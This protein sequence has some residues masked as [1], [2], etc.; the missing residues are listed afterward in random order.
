MF[1]RFVRLA[2]ARRALRAGHY[3]EALR[4]VDDPL[5][6][7]QRRSEELRR[8]ILAALTAR[9]RRRLEGGAISAARVDVERVLGEAGDDA[10]AQ[11]LKAELGARAAETDDRRASQLALLRDARRALGAADPNAAE[12]LVRTASALGPS[13]ELE[14][15]ISAIH[16]ARQRCAE[17]LES[18]AAAGAEGRC[19]DAAAAFAQA[20]AIDRGS[21][22]LASALRDFL[23][24]QGEALVREIER[25]GFEVAIELARW[26][27]SLPE[28]EGV[29]GLTALAK[30]HAASGRERV[31]AALCADDLVAVRA[32]RRDLPQDE[33][34]ERLLELCTVLERAHAAL[35]QG[36]PGAAAAAYA[37]LAEALATPR[38]LA[39]AAELRESVAFADAG[40][41]RARAHALEGRLSEAR[42]ELLGVIARCGAH[43]RAREELEVL[44][45][46]VADRER[47][48]AEAR[49]LLRE[50]RLREASGIVVALAVPGAEGEEPRLLLREIRQRTEIVDAG[51]RQVAVRMH[52]RSSGGREGL[53]QSARRVAELMKLQ[54]D[55][56]ELIRM[57]DAIAAELSGLAL[58]ERL[59]ADFEAGKVAELESGLDELLKLRTRLLTVDRL[60]ARA[61]ELVDDV[62]LGAERAAATGATGRAGALARALAG[63]DPHAP[64]LA[65]RRRA[66]ADSVQA[67][68]GR[69]RVV[70]EQARAALAVNDLARAE[71]LRDAAMALALDDVEVLRLAEELG[72]ARREDDRL[73][74]VARHADERD[75][76]AAHRE[77]GRL[78]PTP[79]LMRTRVFDLKRA[80]AK[81]QGLEGAFMLRVDEGGEFLVVRGESL[82]IG[83]LR[84]GSADLPMLANLAGRHARLRRSMSFHGGQQDRIVAEGGELSADGQRVA[85]LA[86]RGRTRFKLG[87][88]VELEY[89]LPNPRSLTALLTVQGGFQI[90]G[91]D[92]VLWMKDRGRD[93]RIL[94][95]PDRDAHV[96][97][98]GLSRELEIF[99][100]RDGRVRIAVQGPATMDGKPFTG[101]HPVTA[102][103]SI[104]VENIALVMLAWHR[105]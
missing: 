10:K 21:A 12:N 20:K 64:G 51:L 77:L 32:A 31:L 16:A 42:A 98:A 41:A 103:A 93:G 19:R 59:R 15:V 5:L 76:G 1:D 8:E 100:D 85:E 56:P 63:W 95:G 61:L 14:R 44:D 78:G 13:Q 72:R 35:D 84:D 18:A 50:A 79:P 38:L 102:G 4:L 46:G 48:L 37:E 62:L 74:A 91:T 67:A 83:N 87:P 55:H 90:A 68:V 96:V 71:E 26:R 65:A 7:G 39:R 27:E 17:A 101:E 30:A 89:R 75:F 28:L 104:V 58:G 92:R 86:L 3:E 6:A 54:C 66:I 80:I 49:V 53:E 33:S 57:R 81:A 25:S 94:V 34:A 43:E 29:P 40:L 47:R 36:E 82:T 99:A 52:D 69:A 73:A 11:A 105:A 88:T 24:N 97:V 2:Q 22:T 23:A 60:D 70:V 45:R 9:A